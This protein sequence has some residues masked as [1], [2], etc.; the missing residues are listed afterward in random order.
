MT[1]K[2]LYKISKKVERSQTQLTKAGLIALLTFLGFASINALSF[3]VL[4]A[5]T[6]IPLSVLFFLFG[7]G[8]LLP[9]YKD[10]KEQRTPGFEEFWKTRSFI[11]KFIYWYSAIFVSLWL[12]FVSIMTLLSAAHT[13][14]YVFFN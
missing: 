12:L 4:Y 6:L 3:D 11:D 2:L 8:M 14:V 1:P 5:A 7:L 13:I 9:W 10:K